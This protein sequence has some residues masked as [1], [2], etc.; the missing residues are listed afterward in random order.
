M[1]FDAK[2]TLCISEVVR[3]VATILRLVILDALMMLRR[4]WLGAIW[5]TCVFPDYTGSPSG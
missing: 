2:V 4:F 5:L 1:V 3:I